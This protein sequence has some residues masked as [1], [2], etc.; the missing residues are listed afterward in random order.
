MTEGTDSPRRR[1]PLDPRLLRAS[2][3]ARRHVV[4]TAAFAVGNVVAVVVSAIALAGL[5][6]ELIVDP[7][8]RNFGDQAVHLTVLAV[9]LTARA[10]MTY[11][12]DRVARRSAHATID[13][14]RV[15][16]L[17]R[18]TDPAHTSPRRL[19]A[20]R[21]S[22]LT[23]T[24]RGLDRL[25]DYLS[26]YLPALLATAVI[27]PIIVVVEL[28]TDWISG[29]II[30]VTLPLIPI[31]MVLI[32]LVT[33]DRTRRKLEAMS[34]Q[35]AQLVDLMTGLPTLR[36]L[37]R[38]QGPAGQV[39]ELGERLR[40]STMGS[41]RIAFLSGA[42][43][44]LL[45]TLSVALV[46][47]SIG[48]RLVFGEMSLYA[49]VLALVLAPEAYLPLRQIG[50][51]FHNAEDGVAAS[52][53]VLDLIDSDRD[54]S[55]GTADAAPVVVR[56]VPVE[57]DGLGVRGRD[58][59]A[60]RGLS[61]TIR[62]GELTVVRG[63]NGAGKST[64][65]AALLGLQSPDEGRVLIGGRDITT[66]DLDDY[67]RQ[68]AWLPQHPAIVPGTVAENIE[69]FGGR[70]SAAVDEAM[71][72][73][74]FEEVLAELPDGLDTMLGSGGAGLSAGQRQRL[75]LARTLASPAPLL[76]LDEPTAHL[77]DVTA[78]RVLDALIG[79]AR[80]GAAV[81]VV[82]HR[83]AVVDAADHVVDVVKEA[84]GVR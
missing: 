58:G 18:L 3:S 17:D 42:V 33:R 6:S 5:L 39:A 43:L 48:L 76:L 23:V 44:E 35:N 69:L 68:V 26:G 36:A 77:D 30:I 25:S 50:A 64:I 72:A 56:G 81:V 75:A 51:Q 29:V 79:R 52:D 37:G 54:D 65:F 55:R 66:V 24:L 61:A 46:A 8:R 20:E 14:L 10:A 78:D 9:A 67:H 19:L 16:A 84:E 62:P 27:T 53:D 7:A 60:P 2:R 38:A 15:A 73:A 1:P 11:F 31:F 32:G 13:E 59:W 12:G 83:A 22:A 49:G 41:L 28:W 45:A 82:S 80:S 40:R 57:L 21:E 70:E 63:P 71:R 74:A 4:A 47:V 34:R